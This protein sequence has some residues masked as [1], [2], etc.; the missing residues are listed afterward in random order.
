[1]QV[2]RAAKERE[3][4]KIAPLVLKMSSLHTWAPLLMLVGWILL[5]S[6]ILPRLGVPT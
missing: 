1:L 2:S 4:A 5:Q 6:L 3:A